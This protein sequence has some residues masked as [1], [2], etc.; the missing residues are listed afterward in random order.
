MQDTGQTVLAPSIFATN[1]TLPVAFSVYGL[2]LYS[3]LAA[4]FLLVSPRIMGTG[5]VKGLKFA[6]SLCAIWSIYLFEPLPHAKS[7][8]LDSVAYVLADGVALLIMG[9]LSG[10][11]LGQGKDEAIAEEKRKLP[12]T[13]VVPSVVAVAAV[14]VCGRLLQYVACHIYSSFDTRPLETIIWDVATGLVAAVVMLWWSGRIRKMGRIQS[15]LVLG[16]LMFGVNL[17]LFNFLMPLVLAVDIGDLIVRTGVDTLAVTIGCFC[18]MP[19]VP[20]G[21]VEST[22]RRYD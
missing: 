6:L 11:L 5:M 10:L 12:L 15:T 22:K 18:A 17:L 9:A 8:L 1:G 7:I 4:L 19:K 21:E 14:F 13:K 3:M 2:I 16:C 20:Q